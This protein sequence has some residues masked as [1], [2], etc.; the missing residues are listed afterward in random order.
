MQRRHFIRNLG[1]A[2]AAGTALGAAGLSAIQPRR[3][4]LPFAAADNDALPL[5]PSVK[6]RV[7]VVGGGL[8][9]IAASYELLKRG[10]DVTLVERADN[11]GGRLTGWNVDV[12]GEIM[13]MEHGFHGFFNQYYN[14]KGLLEEMGLGGNFKPVLDYPVIF[15]DPAKGT[16]S[17]TNTTTI[18]PFNLFAVVNQARSV[19]ILDFNNPF[20]RL[21]ELMRYDPER[22][23][24]RFDDVD[25]K[26]FCKRVNQPMVDTIIEPFA[27]TSFNQFHRYST[28]EGMKFFHFFFL[29]NPDGMGYDQTIDDA[30]TS[31]VTPM[32]QQLH[33]LGGRVITGV[34]ADRL[35][36]RD[37]RIEKLVMK[38]PGDIQDAP[39]SVPAADIGTDWTAFWQ[40]TN[41][42]YARREADGGYRALSG[43]C[44]HMGC[45]VGLDAATGGFAC[46]CHGAKYDAD[47]SP[48]AGPT[49]VPLVAL[50][51]V[52]DGGTQVALMPRAQQ[53]TPELTAD[54]FV[55]ACD[56]PGLQEIVG[57]SGLGQQGPQEAFGTGVANLGV[58]DPYIVWRLW[59]DR[60]CPPMAVPFYTVSGWRYTDSIA[61]YSQMQPAY[62]DWGRR[63]K[64]SVIELHAYAVE[65]ENVI[66]EAEIKRVMRAEL[67]DLI[68]QLQGATVL[69]DIYTMQQNFPRWAPGDYAGRPGIDTG[70]PNLFLAGDFV[71]LE[72]PANLMEAATMTGRI[73]ANRVLAAEGLRENPIPTVDLTGP[74]VL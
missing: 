26:T 8:A 43:R 53:N 72:V 37:G 73:A 24:A 39:L 25:F 6:K 66:D 62:E 46:P 42:F 48:T 23:F 28:A 18:F 27:H 9:G 51:A 50:D 30:M 7:V 13:A 38:R 33:A 70:L 56:V 11:L 60:E 63:H 2:A 44:T 19:S 5:S 32:T 1:L 15:K 55:L 34:E 47:G 67:D 20:G 29:G 69:Y 74:L 10:F 3:G 12:N 68:P 36:L 35:V 59:L 58:A 71:R 22:T 14:L 21:Y 52:A 57:R 31:V 49:V 61:I 65:P 17:F 16:E 4:V 41:L 64:G 54:Y 40:G 45:P